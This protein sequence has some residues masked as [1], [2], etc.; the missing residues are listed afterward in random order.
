MDLIG[1]IRDEAG[2]ASSTLLSLVTPDENRVVLRIIM[3][4][5]AM[6]QF[7][8]HFPDEAVL[9]KDP[10]F[11]GFLEKLLFPVPILLNILPKIPFHR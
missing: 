1:K 4:V 7:I 6:L 11:Q 3:A 5:E 9:E 2:Q 10:F 8:I